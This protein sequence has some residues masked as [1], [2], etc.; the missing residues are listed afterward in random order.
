M[1]LDD[2]WQ[3]I[4]QKSVSL[5]ANQLRYDRDGKMLFAD[6]ELLVERVAID[7]ALEAVN[8]DRAANDLDSFVWYPGFEQGR[9]HVLRDRDQP[10]EPPIPQ[11]R[12]PARLG[13]VH[14]PCQQCRHTCQRSACA[15]H[16]V[17]TTTAVAVH[18]IKGGILEKP[19]NPQCVTDVVIAT[20]G[21]YR[22]RD[23][24]LGGSFDQVAAGRANE[25]ALDAAAF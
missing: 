5:A 6:A 3:N 10:R 7:G 2:A 24:G 1:L 21:H 13:I 15:T 17:G 18:E 12:Q 22:H 4:E 9:A 25:A 11:P 8:V 14:A 19:A 16:D 23:A 20:A